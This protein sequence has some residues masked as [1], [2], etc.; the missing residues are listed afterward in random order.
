MAQHARS[1]LK[2]ENLEVRGGAVT[3]I[4]F[5]RARLADPA[6]ELACAMDRLEL[7]ALAR[8]ALLEGYGNDTGRKPGPTA[9]ARFRT[10]GA[11]RTR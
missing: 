1:D 4:D 3:L 7:N 10:R 6:W 2:P 9:L 5:E 8:A 11:A